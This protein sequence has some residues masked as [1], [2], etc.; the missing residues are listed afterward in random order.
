MELQRMRFSICLIVLAMLANSATL[1]AQTLADEP[2][3]WGGVEYLLWKTKSAP[4]NVPLVTLGNNVN[5]GRI[6]LGAPVIIGNENLDLPWRSGI[7]ATVGAWLDECGTIGAEGVFIHLAN[8]GKTRGIAD[9]ADVNSTS[10]LTF[11]LFNVNPAFNREGTILLSSPGVFSATTSLNVANRLYSGELNGLY[12]VSRGNGLQVDLIS[13]FRYL[14]FNEKLT[15]ATS[16]P[17]LPNVGTG[18]F[19]TIDRF[20][21]DNNFYGGNIG[22]RASWCLG[23]LGIS[24]TAKCALGVMHQTLDVSGSTTSNAFFGTGGQT[25]NLPGG[26]LALPTNIG[27]TSRDR[28]AVI[29]EGN[30]TMSYAIVD[31]V[32]LS[33]GY[34]FL[35]VSSVGRPGTQI[36]RVINSLQVPSG[37]FPF[38]PA[39]LVGPA[40]PLVV[41]DSTD[42]WAQGVN[43]GL[44]FRF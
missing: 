44:E 43:F 13:G 31:N 33:V 23:A 1:H 26:Y 38:V 12:N 8:Q 34:T 16:S 24:A 42:F 7:R 21:A 28:F 4:V 10:F 9:P 37:T 17:D 27:S 11:P 19:D 40:R 14:N 18:T 3:L 32:R 5:D 39:P 25:I 22:V 2:A 35:Y 30:V 20:N 36:D 41:Q 15:F 6:D 29:P